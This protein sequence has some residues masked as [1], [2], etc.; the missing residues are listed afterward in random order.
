MARLGEAYV[1][2]RADLKDY[3]ADLDKALQRST[4]KF[5]K[6]FNAS[7]GRRVGKAVGT[8]LDTELANA[9]KQFVKDFEESAGQGGRA[10]GRRANQEFRKGFSAHGNPFAVLGG[11][12]T[13]G[14]SA[15]PPQLKTAIGAGFTAAIIPASAAIASAIATGITL[16][17]VGVG[18]ALAFQ[19]EEVETAGTE[20][21]TTLRS[22]AVQAAEGFVAPLLEAFSRIDQF[23]ELLAPT[24]ESIFGSASQFVG[25]LTTGLLGLISQTVTG[26]DELAANSSGLIDAFSESLVILGEALGLTLEILGDM[27]TDGEQALKDL[28]FTGAVL[29]VGFAALLRITTDIYG[30]FRDVA[31]AGG[32]LGNVMRFLSPVLNLA[33]LYFNAIDKSAGKASER[34]RNLEGITQKYIITESGTVK[35]TKA[36]TK[37]L[38]EQAQAMQNVGRAELNII[39]SSLD[40]QE[41]LLDLREVLKENKKEI[42]RNGDATATNTRAGIENVR[43]LERAFVASQDV[44]L[45]QYQRGQISQLQAIELYRQQTE[46]IYRVA[47]AGGVAG[48]DIDRLFGKYNSLFALPPLSDKLFGGFIEGAETAIAFVRE[49]SDRIANVPSLS[50]QGLGG[51]TGPRA[52]SRNRGFQQYAHGGIVDT[53]QLAWVGEGNQPEVILPLNNPRR[54]RELAAQSGL[55]NVLGGD[56]AST[57]IVYV[58]NEQLDSRM[59]R[60]ARNNSQAQARQMT[61]GPRLN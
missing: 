39:N 42:K 6:A 58:G 4:D 17:V 41:S 32:V 34:M 1:R 61:Q 11:L 9:T 51:G 19:F 57:V 50:G 3:D 10:G 33:G 59:Y 12:L 47:T 60:V 22:T 49:L 36:Q 56:G 20:L 5:E 44:I 16:G 35:L 45:A 21:F 2:V 55:M 48:G 37:A 14:F 26:L 40:Y 27:G 29:I 18:T 43:A 38:D 30:A 15:I 7:L 23:F 31:Q 53:E 13:D 46:E 25:P 24:L 52:P 28:V 54:S 8:E